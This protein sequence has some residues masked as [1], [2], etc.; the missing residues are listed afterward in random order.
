MFSLQ[1]QLVNLFPCWGDF[2]HYSKSDCQYNLCQQQEREINS[3]LNKILQLVL[4]EYPCCSQLPVFI[5]IFVLCGYAL[6]YIDIS[7]SCFSKQKRGS[8]NRE[9]E[10]EI[11]RVGNSK[12]Y[13]PNLQGKELTKLTKVSLNGVLQCLLASNIMQ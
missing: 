7:I 11:L 4:V 12:H 9:R 2:T 6:L 3:Q 5:V 13:S 1:Y 8:F 10:R